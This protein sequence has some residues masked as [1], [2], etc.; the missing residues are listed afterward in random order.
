L[1]YPPLL[2]GKTPAEYRSFFESNYCKA[3]VKTFDGVEVRFRKSDFNHCFFES[4]LAKDDTFSPVRAERLLWI[5]AALQDRDSERYVGWNKNLKSYDK[6]RR[7]ALVR[8]NYVV[9]IVLTGEQKADFVTAYV[10]NNERTLRKI[11]S[12]PVWA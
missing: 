2:H 4:I 11:R 1:D 7:V 3:P 6:N 8:G 5:K 9:V 10:A 12:S